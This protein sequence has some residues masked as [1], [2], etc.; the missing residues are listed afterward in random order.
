MDYGTQGIPWHNGE[1]HLLPASVILGS[2]RLDCNV[3]CNLKVNV[4]FLYFFLS[5]SQ[6]TKSALS[7]KVPLPPK[8]SKS[9]AKYCAYRV[10]LKLT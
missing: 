7:V 4:F 2:P 5:F 1:Q 10:N 3:H 9:A 8:V 6:G